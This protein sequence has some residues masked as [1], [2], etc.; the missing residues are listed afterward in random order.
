MEN[1]AVG[2][3]LHTFVMS[4][5]NNYWINKKLLETVKTEKQTTKTSNPLITTQS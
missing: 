3:T 5:D 1:F 2:E 4:K